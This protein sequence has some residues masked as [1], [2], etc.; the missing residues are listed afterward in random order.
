MLEVSATQFVKKFGQYKEQVQR[1][2]IAITSHGRT[3]GYFVSEHDFKEYMLLKANSR[4]AYSINEL[5]EATVSAIA[6]AQMNPSH[7][8]LD[9]L[10]D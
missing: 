4:R 1:E 6:A 5:P 10:M 8:H 2:T 3:S 7:D 9:S